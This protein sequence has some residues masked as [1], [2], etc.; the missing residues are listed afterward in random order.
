VLRQI[1]EGGSATVYLVRDLQDDA[2]RALKVLKPRMAARADL[3]KRV[4]AEA[5]IMAGLEHPNILG[6]YQWG[7][8]GIS[9]Y[10]LMEYAPGGS[11]AGWVARHGAMHARVATAAALEMCAALTVAHDAGVI[12][13]DLKPDNVLI[14]A[15]GSTRLADFGIARLAD[16]DGLTK[17]DMTMGTVGYMAPEQFEDPRTVDPRSDVYSVAATLWFMVC[18]RVPAH[19]FHSDPWESGVPGPLCPLIGRATAYQAAQRQGGARALAADLEAVF[20]R[21]PEVPHDAPSLTVAGAGDTVPSA[22]QPSGEHQHTWV[23]HTP[24]GETS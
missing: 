20:D 22:D 11:L 14:A 2:L 18:G 1:A 7:I 9:P 6:V 5:R 12:H 24:E 8:D 4:Q 21:L 10:I 23:D 19:V 15:D 13:R 17:T 3:R 16:G